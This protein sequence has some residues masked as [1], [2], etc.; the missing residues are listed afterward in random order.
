MAMPERTPPN[1]RTH[2]GRI[3]YVT[4]TK[5][6]KYRVRMFPTIK[7]CKRVSPPAHFRNI[8]I[9]HF[10]LTFTDILVKKAVFPRFL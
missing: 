10:K 1:R 5:N 2:C 6:G 8:I 3:Y 7:K 4:N 9:P